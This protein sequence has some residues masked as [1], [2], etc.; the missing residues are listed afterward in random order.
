M[1][2]ALKITK[3]NISKSQNYNKQYYQ[4]KKV[5][6]HEIE[7]GDQVLLRNFKEKGGTGK[8]HS[9]W[10]NQIYIVVN[11]KDDLP[12]YSIQP[13][14]N[15]KCKIKQVHRNNITSCKHLQIPTNSNDS[16]VKPKCN[17]KPPSC[18][19]PTIRRR[20]KISRNIR[21]SCSS[22]EDIILVERKTNTPDLSPFSTGRG[23][24]ANDTRHY[25]IPHY[26]R[27]RATSSSSESLSSTNYPL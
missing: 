14:N 15:P 3:E 12:V 10:E 21:S 26:Q 23:R 16:S 7:I 27:D 18:P 17:P 1:E 25:H 8:L 4:G 5:F 2:T 24:E 9:H 11:K 22:E 20:T 6:G 13:I 19:P